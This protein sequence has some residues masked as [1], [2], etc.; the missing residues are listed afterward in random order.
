MSGYI[1]DDTLRWYD[2]NDTLDG[3]FGSNRLVGGNGDDT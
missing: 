3:M 1:H 2:G